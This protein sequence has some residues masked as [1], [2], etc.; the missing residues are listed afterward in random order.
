MDLPF[1]LQNFEIVNLS[2]IFESISYAYHESVCVI[3][4]AKQRERVKKHTIL[5]GAINISYNS[6]INRILVNFTF[7]KKVPVPMFPNYPITHWKQ[8]TRK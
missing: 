6:F 1:R 5:V 2:R 7:P 8:S 4:N 3:L